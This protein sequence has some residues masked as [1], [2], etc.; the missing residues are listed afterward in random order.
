M[1]AIIQ[2]Q[3][4][5][6]F[7]EKVSEPL[8]INSTMRLPIQF[9]LDFRCGEFVC[10]LFANMFRYK[11]EKEWNEID[12]KKTDEIIKMSKV[13]YRRLIEHTFFVYPSIFIRPEIRNE[14]QN[15]IKESVQNMKCKITTDENNATHIIHAEIAASKNTYVQ[16]WHTSWASSLN[17]KVSNSRN[18]N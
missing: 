4:E 10:H 14:T 17:D 3:E 13:I 9:F 18:N 2:F 7:F 16:S 1:A 5:N 6:L 11:H 15:R 12:F 8:P